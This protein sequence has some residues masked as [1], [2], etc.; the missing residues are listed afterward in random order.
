VLAF[1]CSHHIGPEL[2]R[3][4][5]FGAAL[6]AGR[7]A[8]VSAELAAPADHPVSLFHPEGRYLTGLLLEVRG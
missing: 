2:F 5:A 3:K 1:S 8:R 4:I 6:D 7:D